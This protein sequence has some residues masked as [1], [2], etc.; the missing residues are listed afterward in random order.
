MVAGTAASAGGWPR[1]VVSPRARARAAVRA[2]R[3]LR[4]AG[5]LVLL[6]GRMRGR[7][8]GGH[9]TYERESALR[10]LRGAT[11]VNEPVST[12]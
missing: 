4:K 5:M 1:P 7:I 8:A 6:I 2:P 9:I 12:S 11:A 3:L 10:I